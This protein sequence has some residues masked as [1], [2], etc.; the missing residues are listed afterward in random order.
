[1]SKRQILGVI[2][3]W[4]I[5]LPFLGLPS[6]WKSILLV[7]TGIGICSL[8]YSTRRAQSSMDSG[9]MDGG[10]GPKNKIFM[11]NTTSEIKSPMNSV[12]DRTV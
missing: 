2:G 6:S 1:M 12:T 4:V 5:I 8:A 11:E 3:V 10:N 7:L 9:D